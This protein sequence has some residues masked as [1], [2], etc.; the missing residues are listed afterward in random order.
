MNN[1]IYYYGFF[2]VFLQCVEVMA[3]LRAEAPGLFAASPILSTGVQ[4]PTTNSAQTRATNSALSSHIAQP[5]AGVEVTTYTGY[6]LNRRRQA[7]RD[8]YTEAKAKIRDNNS[9]SDLLAYDV[10]RSLDHIWVRNNATSAIVFKCSKSGVGPRNFM[11]ELHGSDYRIS[12]WLENRANNQFNN[13]NY[14]GT[15]SPT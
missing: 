6:A 12:E 7:E 4:T 3:A 11:L 13:M 2:F 8:Y 10:H 9:S 14:E 15:V 1:G 5:A